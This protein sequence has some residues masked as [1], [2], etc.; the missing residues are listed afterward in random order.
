MKT[1]IRWFAG[2]PTGANLLMLLFLFLGVLGTP[3]LLRETFPDYAATEVQVQVLWPGAS[4]E[5]VEDAIC[6]RI[7][8]AV[9][10]VVGVKEV[11]SEAREGVGIVT[12][13]MRDGRNFVTFLNEV[14][15]EVDAID[16]FPEDA[17]P[18][19]VRELGKT[20]MV[21]SVAITGPMSEVDLKAYAEEFKDRMK[22]LPDISEIEI[23][24]FSDHQ[25][26]ITLPALSLKQHGLSIQDVAQAVAGQ[27]VDMPAGVVETADENVM[28][29]FTELRRTVPEYENLVVVSSASGAQVRLADIGH[30]VERFEDDE[31]AIIFNGHRAA[32]LQI[33]KT[34]EQ[35][36]LR[37]LDTVKTFLEHERK[38]A[39]AGMTFTLT[40]NVSK[41]VSDRLSMLIKNGIQGLILVFLVMWLFFSFRFSFWVAMGLPV[42]FAGALFIMSQIGFTLNMLTMV[43]LLLALGLIMDDAI[44]LAENI[45]AHLAKGK[46]ALE[47]AID[48][49]IEVAPG[50]F[51]S[52]VT[53][54]SVFGSLALFAAGDIGKV[55][56]VMPVVLILTLSVSLVEAYCILPNHLAHSLRGHEQ[57]SPNRFRRT[58]NVVFERCVDVVVKRGV[59][60]CVRH[61]Y[62]F[63]GVVIGALLI[64]ISLLASGTVKTSAFPDIDG[65]VLEAKLL[66]PQGTPL[67]RTKS[68]VG[69]LVAGLQSVNTE[70]TPQQPDGRS[71]VENIN[72]R[73]G[74]NSDAKEDGTYLAT[75]TADLL[76][77]EER[78]VTVDEVRTAW[79]H[80]V[81]ELPDI[82]SL[83]FTEPAIGP[84]GRAFEIRL[85]G[86]DLNE[87]D[88]ASFELQDGLNR[89]KGVLDVQ[90]DLRP[91][92]KEWR[93]TIKPEARS[94]GF[95]AIDIARQIRTAF[96]GMTADEIQIGG[97]S[98]E[99]DVRLALSDRDSLGDIDIFTLSGK[100]GAQIPLRSLTDIEEGRGWSRISR[101]N[102][103]RA[104]TVIGDVDTRIANA[105]QIMKEIKARVLP[106]ILSR[107]PGV[108]FDL[109][110]QEASG[111]ETGRSMLLAL[112]SGL[113]GVFLLLSLQFRSYLEP[114]AVMVII[115]LTLIGVIW[116]HFFLGYDLSMVSIMGFVSL[117]GIVVNDSILLVEFLRFGVE[118]GLSVTDAAIDASR[119]RFRA[120]LLTSLTTLAGMFPL[121]LERSI[122]AQVLIPLVIS[123]VFG[124]M[125]ST[126]LVLFLVPS[127][128]AIF[129]DFHLTRSS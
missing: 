1:T 17:E 84:A 48:G 79:R 38:V 32:L 120:V 74:F 52:F 33:N 42:S 65:D 114:L 67:E 18:P 104:V 89:F 7:E 59:T 113:F 43:G 72:I 121:L 46:K 9:E 94:L 125:T 108:E 71:L 20:D 123:I 66:M 80:A 30:V 95:E 87:L 91:G 62:L 101:I 24:G 3:Q 77:A 97:E 85:I 98:Y 19:V 54:L 122:Q 69:R 11:R 10:A 2:H 16:D 78:T 34:D 60:S 27:S 127:L 22:R 83:V 76:S 36:A 39:P 29:R 109:E 90:D 96:H 81:G 21:V 115:P 5:D 102:G 53:T 129:N 126:V 92:M 64:S 106:E 25:I 57:A 4:A 31:D 41:I 99:I 26:R 56:W 107:H 93:L 75:I 58:F 61:R 117:T 51:A 28:L 124:L 49:T 86:Y 110:G 105:N 100:D 47:A 13:E 70:L 14:K 50:V 23:L 88:A 73:Y 44:V 82:T 15:T 55:L 116:G 68:V 63:L 40:R 103:L 8:D 12:I 118:K 111:N 35:D 119:Q 37:I 112:V 45:A 6:R 128:Y